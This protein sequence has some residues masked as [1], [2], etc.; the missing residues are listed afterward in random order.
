MMT[1]HWLGKYPSIDAAWKGYVA[2]VSPTDVEAARLAFWTGASVLFY[3]MLR[4]L[5]PGEEPTDADLAKMDRL[6]AEIEKFA[7]TFDAE[8]LKR[9]GGRQ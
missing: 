5:D 3:G 7:A 6:N 4:M 9:R 2:L 8:V 1:H